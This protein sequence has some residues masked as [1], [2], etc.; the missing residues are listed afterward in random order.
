M[1]AV[2]LCVCSARIHTPGK[3]G[4]SPVPLCILYHDTSG[5]RLLAV[6]GVYRDILRRVDVEARAHSV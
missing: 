1:M 3:I 6:G 4:S 5:G 2:D